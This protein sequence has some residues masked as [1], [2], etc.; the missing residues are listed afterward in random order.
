MSVFGRNHYREDLRSSSDYDSGYR[1]GF[2]TYGA[3]AGDGRQPEI[4]KGN[5]LSASQ[6]RH[7]Y[8]ET[9]HPSPRGPS[10]DPPFPP[11]RRRGRSSGA[12]PSVWCFSDPEMRRRKR[13][14]SYKAY[15]VEG[16]LKASLRKGFRWIKTKCSEL[17]HGRCYGKS[18]LASDATCHDCTNAKGSTGRL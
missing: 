3:D 9:S 5:V 4:V 17:V 18:G 7:P 6:T 10:P 2:R 16:K 1:T 11:P 14:A 15:A 8:S 12:A 13:V